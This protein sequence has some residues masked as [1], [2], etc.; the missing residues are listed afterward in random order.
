MTQILILLTVVFF[1]FPVLAGTPAA[2]SR[3]QRDYEQKYQA[4]V[5]QVQGAEDRD[6]QAR[7]WDARP[8]VEEAGGLI[9]REIRNNLSESW[10]LDYASWL[11]ENAPE[12]LAPRPGARR[13][14]GAIRIRQAV[15]KFHLKSP[16]VAPYCIAVTALADPLAM[17]TLEKIEAVNPDKRVKGAAALGQAILLRKLDQGGGSIVRKRQA[18]LRRAAIDGYGLQIGKRSLQSIAQAEIARLVTLSVG[19]EAPDLKGVDIAGKVFSLEDYQGKVRVL[20]FWH[21]W[22]AEADR[23]LGIARRMQES[24]AGKDAVL[25]GINADRARTLRKMTADGDVTW[26]NFFDNKRTLA[27]SYYIDE[28][29]Y[30]IIIDQEGKIRFKGAPGAF[31]EL[32]ATALLND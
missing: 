32:T 1:S 23:A 29:P 2:A 7:A 21:T 28:W 3:Y 15:E 10:T 8:N 24:F 19:S 9:W 26:R 13:V 31:V 6:A 18:K 5:N 12:V 11:L 25:I 17:K 4:W 14:P 20:F 30:M 27:E 16:K 22:M